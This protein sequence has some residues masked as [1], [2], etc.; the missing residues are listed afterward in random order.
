[1]KRRLARILQPAF[2]FT[3]LTGMFG[4]LC[5]TAPA[6]DHIAPLNV[7]EGDKAPDFALKDGGG[8]TV[9]LSDFQGHD[10]LLDFFRG[11]W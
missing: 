3:L 10:V 6:Q 9:R 5:A 2:I 1:M 4:A 7:K 8:K 11:Y